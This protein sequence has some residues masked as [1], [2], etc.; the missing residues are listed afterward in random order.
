MA[1][2]YKKYQT[3][4]LHVKTY[5]SLQQNVKSSYMHALKQGRGGGVG[6]ESMGVGGGWEGVGCL[7]AFRV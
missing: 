6:E 5:H 1:S 3:I 7:K 2:Y 4:L